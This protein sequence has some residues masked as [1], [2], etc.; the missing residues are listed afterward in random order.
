[1]RRFAAIAIIVW[2]WVISAHAQSALNPSD[3]LDRAIAS[4]LYPSITT[5]LDGKSQA[6]KSVF[7][8]GLRD[9]A[10]D[11]TLIAYA[12]AILIRHRCRTG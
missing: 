4:V 12:K 2:V 11:S 7:A 1:M 6:Y 9:G 3:S 5:E 10:A 8:K